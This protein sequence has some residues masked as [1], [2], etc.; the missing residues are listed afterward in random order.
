MLIVGLVSSEEERCEV[1]FIA[2]IATVETRFRYL[3]R[4]Q[5]EKTNNLSFSG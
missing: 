4:T 2:H 3:G 1:R 5:R